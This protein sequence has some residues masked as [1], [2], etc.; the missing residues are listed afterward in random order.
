M[1]NYIYL[2]ILQSHLC[3][4][5]IKQ[6]IHVEIVHI[7]EIYLLPMLLKQKIGFYDKSTKGFQSLVLKSALKKV[8]MTS[9]LLFNALDNSIYESSLLYFKDKFIFFNLT[10]FQLFIIHLLII[11]YRM[12]YWQNNPAPKQNAINL[13][14]TPIILLLWHM[15]EHLEEKG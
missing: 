6:R 13:F 5:W 12:N 7:R 2:G 15:I 11:H 14:H 1:I 4:K 10:L 3:D 8:F 9:N